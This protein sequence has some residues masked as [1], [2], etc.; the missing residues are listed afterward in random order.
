MS[1]H[2]LSIQG[3]SR[4]FAARK[5]A[6]PARHARFFDTLEDRRLMSVGPAAIPN[7]TTNDSVYDADASLLHVVYYD[8]QA[9]SLN[10]QSFNNDGTANAPAVIDNSADVGQLMS[11]TQDSTGVLHA[12][13]Y[14]GTNG[15]LKYAR[16]DLAGTWSTQV[17]DSKN[18]VGLYPSIAIAADGRPAISYYAKTGGNL[19]FAKFDGAAWGIASIDVT[20]DVGRYSSLA[21]NPVTNR[22][23]I[24]FEDTTTGHFR[25]AE[26]SAGGT[27]TAV[28]A[29]A[30]TLGGGGFTSLA[31]NNGN[32]AFSYYDAHNADLKYAERSSRGKW[33][34]TTVAA[35]NS[36]GLYTD[37]A[38]T[39]DTNQPAIV[40]YNKSTDSVLLTYRAPG[41]AW[42]F[43]VEATGGGRNVT[44]TDGPSVGGQT[45]ALFLVYT[46][47][48]TGGLTVQTI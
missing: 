9:K 14:D 35:K 27:W 5:A 12:A 46:D 3:S 2:T 37:L 8:A 30:T 13:Y 11:I 4:H 36:Q 16:R 19:K 25:F 1:K 26:Q 39:F 33:S 23:G 21:L 29:D 32:P 41:G 6:R 17:V 24:S 44:A 15:D 47:T 31:Y 45:P 34:N 43:E 42:Q 28:D 10:Y 40:Y 18:T 38:W 7:A 48:A 22:F 20:N